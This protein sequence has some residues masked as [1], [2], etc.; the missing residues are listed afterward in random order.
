[1][2]WRC[3]FAAVVLALVSPL[4]LLPASP[5]AHA[6][7]EPSDAGAKRRIAGACRAETLRFCPAFEDR[8]PTP[9]NLAICL[10]SYKTSLSF[11]CRSAVNAVMR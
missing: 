2:S 4:V 3:I 10:K 9:R 6:Q 1:M 7:S 11:N 5:K 8:T